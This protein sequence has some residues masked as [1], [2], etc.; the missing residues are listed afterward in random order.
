MRGTFE[1]SERVRG[2]IVDEIHAL[3][4]CNDQLRGDVERLTAE[5][6]G[7]NRL[8]D[9]MKAELE[10][11]P[12]DLEKKLEAAE[13][14]INLIEPDFQSILAY[15]DRMAQWRLSDACRQYKIY[16]GMA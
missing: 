12:A 6:E 9:L 2:Q 13:R 15:E 1:L 16:K 14:L 10:S 7:L 5:V 11:R 4:V 3:E 8:I